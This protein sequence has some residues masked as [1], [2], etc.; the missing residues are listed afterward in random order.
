MP[1]APYLALVKLGTGAKG[2]NQL[3]SDYSCPKHVLGWI[4]LLVLSY[5]FNMDINTFIVVSHHS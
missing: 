5:H 2:I 3:T 1:Y 4:S